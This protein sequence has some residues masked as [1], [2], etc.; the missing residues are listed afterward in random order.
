MLFRSSDTYIRNILC[1]FFPLISAEN[2]VLRS[3]DE[4]GCCSA[5][6]GFGFGCRV[7]IRTR[8]LVLVRGVFRRFRFGFGCRVQV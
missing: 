6:L 7:Q 4:L 2:A 1:I 3:R 5:G 8:L